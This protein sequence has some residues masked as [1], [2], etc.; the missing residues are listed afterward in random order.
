MIK[1]IVLWNFKEN[2]TVLER[3]NASARIKKELE[4][5]KPLVNGVLEL[6][7]ICNKMNSSN[8]DIALISTFSSKEALEQYQVHPAHIQ[9]GTFIKSVTENR[10]CMDY[11]I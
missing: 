9:A 5:I 10:S 8:R 7:V 1:H 2:L 4:A 3:D 11:E 6:Q